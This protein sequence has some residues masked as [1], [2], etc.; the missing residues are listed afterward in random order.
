MTTG[1]GASAGAGLRKAR[2][3]KRRATAVFAAAG[4][5][6][7]AVLAGCGSSDSDSGSAATDTAGGDTT[8][9]VVD[10]SEDNPLKGSSPTNMQGKSL[11]FGYSRIGGWPPSAAP[12]AMW[13]QFQ[14]YA[15]ENFGYDVE[16]TFVEAPFG[17]LFQKIAPTLAAG[18]QEYNLMIVDSQWL[19]ALAEPGW[20]VAADKVY[21]LNPELDIEPFS[22][23]VTSTYQV[24]PDGSGQRWGFPQMPDT[25]GVFLRLDML[26]DPAE[27]AAFEAA[28][29]KKL[30]TTYEE[31]ENIMIDDLVEIFAF[32]NRPDEGMYGTA[33]QYSKDYDFFSCAYYPFAYSQ[34][35]EIWD[36][37]TKQ[38]WGILNSDINAKA[39]EEFVALKD[40]QPP[41]FATQGI[42]EV[43]DLFS[44][45]RVFSGWQWLA[46]GKFM[47]PPELEGKVLAIPLPKWN[48][49]DGQPNVIG[50]MG[51]QPWVINAFNDDDH[52][53]V[54]IDFLK[55]WYLPDTQDEF[56]M[57]QGGL[58]WS[59]EGLNNEK[60]LNAFP[61]VKPFKYMLEEGRSQDFWHE[62]EYSQ[63][64]AIQQE[65]WNAYATG[66]VTSAKAAL[67][68]TAAKQQEILYNAGRTQEPPPE[69]TANLT[70]Q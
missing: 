42:G 16:L 43:I 5:V 9:Q 24:Y 23:L 35:G 68:Y 57:N 61:Y 19:G 29:G 2:R 58:P 32:F 11:T 33:L 39:M 70:L 37:A 59:K 54:A 56:I 69:G 50:A 13:P 62:P 63:M 53:R 12:E 38:I 18:S 7:T 31:Y 17:E 6:A 67:D 30:P 10:D 46:V 40:L 28:T 60:Y 41:S 48:G 1:V 65:A 52:M 27:Q 4:L 51:G 3:H 14:A 26:E 64:L 49:P 34:G 45:G 36:P 22:S 20:I 25:Q 8:E 21:E 15:K 55:W 47:I 44:T 66:Q